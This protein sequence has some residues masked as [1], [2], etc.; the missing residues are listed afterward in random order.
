VKLSISKSQKSFF[1]FSENQ[2]IFKYFKHNESL[3]LLQLILP[4]CNH[5][6][7]SSRNQ[8]PNKH[9]TVK[10]ALQIAAACCLLPAAPVRPALT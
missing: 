10:R 5:G 3:Q 4:G 1:L 7:L 9:K 6:T 8:A 2:S